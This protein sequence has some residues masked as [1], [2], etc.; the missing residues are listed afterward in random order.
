MA[1]R[2]HAS[3]QGSTDIPTLYDLLSGYMPQPSA[4]L[5]PVPHATDSPGATTWGETRDA[6][7]NALSQQTLQEYVDSSG[8]K[9]GWWSNTPAYMRSFLHAWYGEAADEEDGNCSYRLIPKII[10]DHSHLVTSYQM[11]DGKVKGYLLF[12]Q[13]PAAGSTNARMQRKALEQLDWMVVR[14][15]YEVE[16]GGVLV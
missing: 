8:Q 16:I 7:T 9:L 1:L 6:K 2:G 11:L 12:G 13:N 3:I 14:D 5:T 4:L 15:L 10:G